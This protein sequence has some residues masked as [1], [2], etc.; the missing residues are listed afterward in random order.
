M[1]EKHRKHAKA[2]SNSVFSI[3][4]QYFAGRPKS[5]KCANLCPHIKYNIILLLFR[6]RQKN[7]SKLNFVQRGFTKETI[8]A[9]C[10]LVYI[11]IYNFCFALIGRGA[12]EKFKIYVGTKFTLKRVTSCQ[13]SF[14]FTMEETHLVSSV[15]H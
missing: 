5:L 3:L 1:H 2:Y 13:T 6:C 4:P 11:H 9:V 8:S 7:P 14:I 12:T 10:S 15:L